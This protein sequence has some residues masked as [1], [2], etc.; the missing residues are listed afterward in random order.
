MQQLALNLKDH[1]PFLGEDGRDP[2]LHAVLLR[3]FSAKSQTNPNRPAI[4]ILPG[5]GYGLLSVRERE[6]S[7]FRSSPAALTF[8]SSSTPLHRIAIPRRSWKWQ[9]QWI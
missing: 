7:G 8:L 3:N 2:I 9:R 1:Y 6:R 5:G 4:L